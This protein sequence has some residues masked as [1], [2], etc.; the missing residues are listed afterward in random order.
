MTEYKKQTVAMKLILLSEKNN[1]IEKTAGYRKVKSMI[2][3]LFSIYSIYHYFGREVRIC[4]KFDLE[5][6][7]KT[8]GT[9]YNSHQ[10]SGICEHFLKSHT[11]CKTKLI[12]FVI[13]YI[14]ATTAFL[15]CDKK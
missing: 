5:I 6:L 9:E 3:F 1:E 7:Y 10:Q 2:W 12:L 11:K 14:W 4:F 13:E 15:I 8:M